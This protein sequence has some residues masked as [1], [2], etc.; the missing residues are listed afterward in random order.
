MS[1]SLADRLKEEEPGAEREFL[2]WRRTARRSDRDSTYDDAFGMDTNEAI[3]LLITI[4]RRQRLGPL[5]GFPVVATYKAVRD[6]FW[7]NLDA[8]EQLW[9]SEKSNPDRKW[10]ECLTELL[11][12]GTRNSLR[13]IAEAHA[14]AFLRKCR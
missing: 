9:R 2:K 14:R 7:R 3:R 5:R 1:K 12:D 4:R 13:R 8:L 6:D 11:N 10:R